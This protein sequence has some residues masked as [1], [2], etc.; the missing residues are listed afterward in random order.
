MSYTWTVCSTRAWWDRQVIKHYCYIWYAWHLMKET[1]QLNINWPH[2]LNISLD[3]GSQT[4]DFKIWNTPFLGGE[5]V[6]KLIYLL[7]YSMKHSPSSEANQFSA[8][9]EIP[10]ILRNPKVYYCIHK[11]P[12]PVPILSH[13]DPVHASTSHL[14]KIHLNIILPSMS[15]S[16]KW[17]LSLR[18]P[19]QN[20]VYTFPLPPYMLHALLISFFS[21]WLPEQYWARGR[22]H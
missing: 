21:I 18:F 16:T 8:S 9:Q 3:Y 13:I 5:S 1:V 10:H 7:T 11:C 15:G 12:P 14:L 22:N 17:S 20:P 6:I 19:H 4:S 2:D